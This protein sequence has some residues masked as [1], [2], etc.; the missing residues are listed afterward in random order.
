MFALF[1]RN[2]KAAVLAG[3]FTVATALSAEAQNRILYT[4]E[5]PSADELEDLLFPG[6]SDA[7]SGF[8][9]PT[10]GIVIH[11]HP[12]PQTP[13][14]DTA[15]E[16]EGDPAPAPSAPVA[17]APVQYASTNTI[18]G[19]T[20]NF[21]FDSTEIKPES[22]GYLDSMGELLSRPEHVGARMRIVGHTDSL[23]PESYN[24]NLS[25]RRAAAVRDFLVQRYDVDPSRLLTEGRGELDL[26]DGFQATA[27]ENRR[28]EFQAEG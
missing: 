1:S 13:V 21:E 25:E 15:L 20:I 24:Q 18:V 2:A 27:A 11:K 23:G 5:A 9:G 17:E 26:L 7:G 3:I 4:D 12:Q 22:Y 10:R 28:V 6:Q 19:F 8:P 14:Q 16:A